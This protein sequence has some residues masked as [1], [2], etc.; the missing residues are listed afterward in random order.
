MERFSIKKNE[1]NPNNW[2][3]TD[4]MYH[5]V[6]TFE[7]RMYSETRSVI[8]VLDNNH[9]HKQIEEIYGEMEEW[10]LQNCP[11][12]AF[13]ESKGVFMNEFVGN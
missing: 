9:C 13:D 11:D 12:K 5:I 1:N 6:A 3:C 8:A 4:N 7:N 2:E 10:L